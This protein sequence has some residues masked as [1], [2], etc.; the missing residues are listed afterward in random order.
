MHRKGKKTRRN[1]TTACR[2]CRKRKSKC[3]GEQPKCERCFRHGLRCEYPNLS[4]KRG[5]PRGARNVVNKE[6]PKNKLDEITTDILY[7]VA[8]V[9]VNTFNS[10]IPNIEPS[11]DSTHN[12]HWSY[13][14][15]NVC[16][17]EIP[18]QSQNLSMFTPSCQYYNAELHLPETYIVNPSSL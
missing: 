17:N 8:T 15:H 2:N 18:V 12:M 6:N 1:V 11:F 4:T 7:A 9:A 16:F 13:P 3:S 5:P 14:N 10:S